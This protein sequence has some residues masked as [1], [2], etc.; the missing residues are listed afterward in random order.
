M[1][2]KTEDY[3][4][5]DVTGLEHFISGQI[6]PVR[7]GGARRALKYED[8]LFLREGF[9]E[10][11]NW[12]TA[13]GQNVEK[14]V[15]AG[16]LLKGNAMKEACVTAIRNVLH[17]YIDADAALPS[18]VSSITDG[19]VYAKDFESKVSG[20]VLTWAELNALAFQ[21]TLKLERLEEAYANLAKMTRTR[22][23]EFDITRLFTSRTMVRHEKDSTGY[24]RTYPHSG[25]N[26]ILLYQW[27]STEDED[28]NWGAWVDEI[29]E[30]PKTDAGYQYAKTATLLLGVHTTINMKEYDDWYPVQLN[31]SQ[32]G[33]LSMA[34][35]T[36]AAAA[37][38]VLSSHGETYRTEPGKNGNKQISMLSVM[39]VLVV[40]HKF[41]AQV[42]D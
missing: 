4:I 9:L 18:G 21:S 1:L 26:Y 6:L 30:T 33:K 23:F 17:D 12:R 14:V 16:R 32:E 35:G 31:V 19:E 15:P 27:G 2:R 40:D 29:T 41:P 13:S 5:L 42:D 8:Y 38:A 34:A 20:D 22:E 37:A 25:Q 28:G 11:A 3:K 39:E 36:L 7:K 10:R 24:D